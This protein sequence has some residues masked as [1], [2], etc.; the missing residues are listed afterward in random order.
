MAERIPLATQEVRWFFEGRADQHGSLKRWFETVVPVERS[1]EVGGP[2]WRGRIGDQ[3]DVYLLVPRGDDMGIKWRE[4]ELQIK[5]RVSCIGTRVFC[6]RHQGKVERWMKWSY[7]DIP[8]AYQRLFATREETGLITAAVRKTRAL[9]KLR[10]DTFT[11]EAQEI[12]PNTFVNRGLHLDLTDLEVAGKTYCSLAVE[13]F[14]DDSAMDAAFTQALEAFLDGLAEP[15]LSAAQ[16]QSYPAFLRDL[17][18][19]AGRGMS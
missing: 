7:A 13:A 17:I 6:G 10:L 4:G 8:A 18:Q 14:P 9:R 1:P 12:D 15:V 19:E 11:G 2:V 3:P 5:G 16:S